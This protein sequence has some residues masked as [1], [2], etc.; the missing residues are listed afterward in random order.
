MRIDTLCRHYQITFK[1]P[2]DVLDWVYHDLQHMGFEGEELM[3]YVA[4]AKAYLKM[5]S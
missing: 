1:A 3:S 4:E 5:E 2:E